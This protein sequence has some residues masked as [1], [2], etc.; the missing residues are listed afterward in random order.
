MWDLIL[1]CGNKVSKRPW[2]TTQIILKNLTILNGDS[3]YAVV[4]LGRYSLKK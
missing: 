2:D 4:L 3:V 1:Q